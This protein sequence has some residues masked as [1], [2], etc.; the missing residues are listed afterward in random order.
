M[1]SVSGRM[2]VIH[3]D[4]RDITVIVD[5][6]H[7]PAALENVYETIESFYVA[8]GDGHVD[9]SKTPTM[10]RVEKLIAVL[11][12]VGGGRDTAKR[13]KLGALASKFAKY[14]IITNED[15][16]DDD[17]SEIM[18]QVEVGVK[19][20]PKRGINQNYWN[21]LDRREAIKK[22]IELAQPG[23]IIALTGKGC[24]EVIAVKG[25]FVPWDDRKVVREVLELT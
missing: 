18:R 12:A 6:A 24:E 21:I 4:K 10:G 5:Y 20:D 7:D 22:A 8:H 11:G 17:P 3:D 9:Q 19:A 1:S 2:E 13:P 25:G 23:D 16:Y 14:V 15:P